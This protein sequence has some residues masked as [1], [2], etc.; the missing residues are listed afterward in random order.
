M[1]RVPLSVLIPTYNEEKNIRAC[2]ESVSWADEI[3]VVDAHSKD[4]TVR[5]AEQH[6]AR[7]LQHTERNPTA[8]K[9][10][11]LPQT[12]H[13]WVLIVD[14][15]ERVPPALQDEILALLG[16]RPDHRGYLIRRKNHFYEQPI[17][18]GGWKN[19]RVLRLFDR[20]KGRYTDRLVH[21]TVEILG[22]TPCLNNRLLHYTFQDFHRYMEKINRYTDW[23]ARQLDRE[24][25][26]A[27]I[28]HLAFR[29]LHHFI[30]SY[31]LRLGFLDGI[32]GLALA[33]LGAFSV[34]LKYVKLWEL[35]QTQHL[36][37]NQ[38]LPADEHAATNTLQEK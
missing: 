24:G 19:D 8:Q 31:L 32:A 28:A 30:K 35:H 7:V 14:A 20:N 22:P 17:H 25:R 37:G 16:S 21:E 12:T 2:L 26:R 5:I 11:A 15:D 3:V 33:S 29:P 36:A 4:R 23:G 38:D 27:N 13:P 10:W 1:S 18:Y 6:A 34:F 9:N